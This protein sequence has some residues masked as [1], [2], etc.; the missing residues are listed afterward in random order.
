MV[1]SRY[2]R[3]DALKLTKTGSVYKTTQ[4]Q[5]RCAP[6]LNK[7]LPTTD[8]HWQR[9]NQ[10]S[11]MACHWV[12]PPHP[13]AG[14]VPEQLANTEWTQWY[15]CGVFVLFCFAIFLFYRSFACFIFLFCLSVC[16]LIFFFLFF[17]EREKSQQS[18]MGK[19]WGGAGRE[20]ND[21][22]WKK[23]SSKKIGGNNPWV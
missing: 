8:A 20:K 1:S 12:Y 23:S 2:S 19:A 4:V 5:A 10:F 7:K 9:E 14:S 22:E 3:A 13:R 15:F 11:P 21:T 18:W 16:V 17:Y 6:T